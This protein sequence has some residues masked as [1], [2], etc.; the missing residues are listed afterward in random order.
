MNMVGMSQIYLNKPM[1][2]LSTVSRYFLGKLANLNLQARIF[3]FVLTRRK[4]VKKVP[5]C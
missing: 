4:I 2:C 5:H 1:A 3:K